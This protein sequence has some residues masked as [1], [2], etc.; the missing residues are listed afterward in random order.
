MKVGTW[1][2]ATCLRLGSSGQDCHGVYQEVARYCASPQR[3]AKLAG[4]ST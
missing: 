3:A 4:P 1:V 2:A